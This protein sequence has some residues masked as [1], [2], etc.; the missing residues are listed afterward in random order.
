MT[1]RDATAKASADASTTAKCKSR[2]P[3]GM[4]TKK[5]KT[6]FVARE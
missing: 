2:S 3:A 4:T 6:Q 1:T 5:A